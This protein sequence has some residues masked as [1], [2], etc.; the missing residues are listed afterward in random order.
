MRYTV[1]NLIHYSSFYHQKFKS[2]KCITSNS[3]LFCFSATGAD[4]R[5]NKVKP[6]GESKSRQ[7]NLEHCNTKGSVN[8]DVNHICD[9]IKI[10]LGL[11]SCPAVMC[12]HATV[13]PTTCS[14]LTAHLP[15]TVDLHFLQTSCHAFR[16]LFLFQCC[17]AVACWG[18]WQFA[19][20]P[21]LMCFHFSGQFHWC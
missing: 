1:L 10:S 2:S 16:M 8:D 4:R 5:S 18:S 21:V 3:D 14:T 9:A 6:L 7:P 19:L 13:V 11:K 12:F 15:Q 17:P 20:L